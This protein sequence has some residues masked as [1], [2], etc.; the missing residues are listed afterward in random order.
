MK[1]IYLFI[2][3]AFF[4][5]L[6]WGQNFTEDFNYVT[7]TT[8]AGNNG[9]TIINTSGTTN[10][11]TV[12]SSGL[13][14]TDALSNNS[15]SN[16][17]GFG[18]NMTTSGQRIGRFLSTVTTGSMYMSFFINVS[19]AGTV[20]TLGS[21]FAGI[22]STQS[23]AP[24]A[25][26]RVFTRGVT[27]GGFN[28]G[29]GKTA[30]T[31]IAS[32]NY[33]STVRTLNTTY[34]V[35][36]KY[37]FNSGTTTDD[38]VSM[39][40]NPILGSTEPTPDRTIGAGIND[41]TAVNG[42]TGPH[43]I[44]RD[45]ASPTCEIDGVRYGNSWAYVTPMA[46]PTI[47]VNPSVPLVIGAVPIN[48]ISPSVSFNLSGVFLSPAPGI[49]TVTSPNPDF[50]VSSDNI[51]FSSSI[52]IANITA[53]LAATAVYVRFSSA[54]AAAATVNL[55]ISG[56]GVAV[57]PTVTVNASAATPYF[58]K[59]TGSL[60]V[61]GTWGTISDGT[62]TAPM[63]FVTDN[64]IFTITNRATHTLDDNFQVFGIGSKIVV[65]DGT[66]PIRLI[67][68]TG[69]TV[70]NDVDHKVDIK[71]NATLE[72]ANKIYRST[73]PG[74]FSKTPFPYFGV[75]DNNSTVE[76]T[77]NGT[78]VIDT[79]RIPAETFGNL[80][81]V[82]GLKYFSSGFAFANGTLDITNVVGLN[83]T[84][85][86]SASILVRGNITMSNSFFDTDAFAD[87]N[88]INLNVGGIATQTL[89][90]GDFYV[91]QLR[92]QAVSPTVP[93]FALD[94]ILGANSNLITGTTTAGGINLQQPLHNLSLN[95]KTLT[96]GNGSSFLS[97]NQGTISGTST[98]NLI[99]NKTVGTSAIGTARFATGG[100][101]LNDFNFNSAGAGTN[102]LTLNSPLT[103]NGIV[104]LNAGNILLG[105]STLTA[106]GTISGGSLASHIVTNGTG[107]LKINGVGAITKTFPVGPSATAYHP[108][109]LNN[110]GTL[111][112]FSV[113]VA[114]VAPP[115]G[116]AA[117]SV[118]ARWNIT[119]ETTGGSNC[120]ISLDYNGA[121]FG[122][123]YLPASAKVI[124]CGGTAPFYNNGSVSGT[125]ASGAGFTSFSP[126]GITSDAVVLPVSFINFSGSRIGKSNKLTWITAAE[127]NNL[128]FDVERSL[129]GQNYTS[130]AFVNTQASGGSSTTN[131][132][133]NFTDDKI[134]TGT[135]QYYRLRQVDINNQ[136]RYSAIVKIKGEQATILTIDGIAPNPVQ[137]SLIASISSPTK[138][139]INLQVVDMMGRMIQQQQ[140]TI[141]EGTN[142]ISVNVSSLSSGIYLLKAIFSDN[143]QIPA[144]K[145]IKE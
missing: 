62:G 22:M 89:S 125:I 51:T 133:Y 102:N 54:T 15:S 120:A 114:S 95:G 63:D 104:S 113:N 13:N 28:F 140:V 84:G 108:A 96:M 130:I 17:I 40:I 145:F 106:A 112:N 58:S 94:I 129:D 139:L 44:Q 119:E 21:N 126:F 73:G 100:Q 29:V 110:S 103:V 59:P 143:N 93:A 132:T 107:A 30:I 71:N 78:D 111:D 46:V 75:M 92:T 26:A 101:V 144:I 24:G 85:N 32:I 134:N 45:A 127:Q 76:Y 67:L 82:N 33:E 105:S 35:V 1:K 79:V 18:V 6:S 131:L 39:W 117:S 77:W 70:L 109:T 5:S 68:P 36:L 9:W 72:I 98:S 65:G 57:P 50:Q 56:G 122:A 91:G 4:S 10:A 121:L 8:L 87:A 55:T 11:F 43:F 81:L 41:V 31:P 23:T 99:I 116:D 66:N 86:G 53:T 69:F 115:C 128:G 49:I 137:N 38:I 19:A 37:T 7:G 118:T 2:I 136:S 138:N 141:Q 14:Y 74:D 16:G 48:T 124:D 83:G 90:G 135:V 42:L 3:A 80:K 88:R 25:G 47:T 61:V 97:T 123:S 142:V 60:H 20:T 12:N 64:Q 52:N 34:L 27:G